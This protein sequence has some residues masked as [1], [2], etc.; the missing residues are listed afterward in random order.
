M[1]WTGRNSNRKRRLAE[2]LNAKISEKKARQ[3]EDIQRDKQS[4]DEK[5]RREL[6]SRQ[7]NEA[8][9]LRAET[10]RDLIS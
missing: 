2:F 7:E 1:L 3:D 10:E 4:Q 5:L 9:L 8:E 6:R